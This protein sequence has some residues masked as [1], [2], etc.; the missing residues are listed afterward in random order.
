MY[1][2]PGKVFL[3]ADRSQLLRGILE[4]CILKIIECNETYGYKIAEKLQMY[5]FKDISEG[6][7]YPLLLRLEKNEIIDF[8]KKESAYGPKRKYYRLTDK[9]QNELRE[10]YTVWCEV[11]NGMNLMF[12]DEKRI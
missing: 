3:L 5:G 1:K 11:Q 7:I 9:G 2:I 8:I 12:K 10:F 6:T 4:G